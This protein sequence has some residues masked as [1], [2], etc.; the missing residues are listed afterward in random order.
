VAAGGQRAIVGVDHDI[1]PTTPRRRTV[2]FQPV[3][4]WPTTELWKSSVLQQCVD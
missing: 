2:E 3:F 4:R 1:A